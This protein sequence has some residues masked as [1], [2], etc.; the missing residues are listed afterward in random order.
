MCRADADA[1]GRV[2]DFERLHQVFVIGQRLAHAHENEVVDLCPGGALGLDNLRDDFAGREVALPAFQ[3]AGAKLASVGAADL[4]RDA[5]GEAV[6][7]FAEHVERGRD[8]DAF[9]VIAGAQLPEQFSRRV[10]R[11]LELDQLERG[12]VVGRVELVPHR[13]GQVG[14]LRD[15]IDALGV[16]PFRNLLAAIRAA[17]AENPLRGRLVEQER[18]EGLH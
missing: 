10:V 11:A 8:E 18:A 15:R 17:V 3:P 4:G 7:A 14:H 9:D 16:E 12:E 1:P 2:D 5:K 13:R 6:G